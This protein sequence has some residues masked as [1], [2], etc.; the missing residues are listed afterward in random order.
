MTTT[1]QTEDQ[2]P[3]AIETPIQRY[4]RLG[5]AAAAVQAMGFDRL[6]IY[7]RE[8]ITIVTTKDCL[9]QIHGLCVARHGP[10]DADTAVNVRVF[11]AGYMIV[12]YPAN[13]FE[14]LDAQLVVD[15]REVAAPLLASFEQICA[16]CDTVGFDGVPHNLSHQFVQQLPTYMT[17]FRAWKIPDEAK[18]SQRI[19]H[20]LTALYDALA[21][22]P[23]ADALTEELNSQ[24]ERLRTKLLQIAGHQVLADF[25]AARQQ[26][27]QQ[28][29]QQLVMAPYRIPTRLSNEQLAHE[30]LLDPTFQLNEDGMTHPFD[31][32]RSSFHNAFW[33]SL[34]GD[35]N[36][37]PPCTTRV[38]R[39]VHEISDAVNQMSRGPL[40][41]MDL[42]R[43]QVGL[44][45]WPNC[46]AL[47]D[48]IFGCIEHIQAPFP[49]MQQEMR[50]KWAQEVRPA[51]TTPADEPRVFC[52]TLR[53]FIDS[54]N[55]ARI[56]AANARLRLLAPVV[57][58]HG[59]D[60]E[61]CK[62]QDKL[63]AGT[64][65]LARTEAWIAAAVGSV[66][67]VERQALRAGSG[68]A[69]F[70]LHT[71]AMF[72]LLSSAAELPETLSLDAQRITQLRA[73]LPLLGLVATMLT[74]LHPQR[75][76]SV[77]DI[78]RRLVELQDT[79]DIAGILED[80]ALERYVSPLDPV[81]MVMAQRVRDAFDC[82]Y[83]GARTDDRF[84]ATAGALL[85]RIAR[86][87]AQFRAVARL[88][89]EVH[90]ERYNAL[91]AA[92]VA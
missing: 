32:I 20:A 48:H 35:L 68:P 63:N 24:I 66:S 41:D 52:S 34:V 44:Y 79:G 26:P 40:V 86:A 36:L 76:Q 19:R 59:L 31:A 54:A 84:N 82:L 89:L 15:L 11:M 50:A 46:V 55:A 22:V 10:T 64:I 69:Y 90:G 60:Y 3:T 13:V 16:L 56:A 21:A 17:R 58:E 33:D 30:L 7:L 39:V 5:P 62:L 25:D 8:N 61:R 27:A 1:S 28:P 43:Q 6:V 38:V 88:N 23:P 9:Q 81:H 42:I 72:S 51:M 65:T 18:L 45:S 75:S 12:H 77:D 14:D 85:P 49:A 87:A 2:Q 91:I 83:R 70:R 4:M 73:E 74:T 80:L 92:A 57:C 67:D 29:A 53:F 78:T 37:A 71:T 47:A